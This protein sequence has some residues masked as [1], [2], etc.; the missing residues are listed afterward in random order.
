MELWYYLTANAWG[1]LMFLITLTII[2]V[3]GGFFLRVI[4]KSTKKTIR[5]IKKK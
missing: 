3:V 2:W 1:A 4:G 5:V